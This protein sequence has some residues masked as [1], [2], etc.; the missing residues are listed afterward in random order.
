MIL[1]QPPVSPIMISPNE[2]IP[3]NSLI[4]LPPGVF[5]HL[6]SLFPSNSTD[7]EKIRVVVSLLQLALQSEDDL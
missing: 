6:E 3:I 4:S 7:S 5:A 1:G 2:A